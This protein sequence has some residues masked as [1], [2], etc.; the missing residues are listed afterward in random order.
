MFVFEAVAL[1]VLVAEFAEELGKRELDPLG[2][3]LVPSCGAEEVAAFARA[4]LLHLL[5][6]NHAG[7]VVA[8]RLDLG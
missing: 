7:Q 6:A 3:E 1:V 8:L 4:D 2:F 5:H